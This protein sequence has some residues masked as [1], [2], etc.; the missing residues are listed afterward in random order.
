MVHRDQYDVLTPDVLVHPVRSME[1]QDISA[2][3][4]SN[5]QLV[6]R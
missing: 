1:V 4:Q 6:G 3:G 2:Q 5:V